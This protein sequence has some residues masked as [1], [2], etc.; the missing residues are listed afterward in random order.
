MLLEVAHKQLSKVEVHKRFG[1]LTFLKIRTLNIDVNALIAEAPV[2]PHIP[3]QR[4][5]RSNTHVNVKHFEAIRLRLVLKGFA[6]VKCIKLPF[7]TRQ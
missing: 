6:L 7:S 5:H 1:V 4:M 2:L 3:Q